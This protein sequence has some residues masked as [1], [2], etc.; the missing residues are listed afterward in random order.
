M[1]DAIMLAVLAPYT[2]VRDWVRAL[3][4]LVRG[5]RELSAPAPSVNAA[6]AAVVPINRLLPNSTP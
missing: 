3:W 5:A 4:T 6:L 2:N 1:P